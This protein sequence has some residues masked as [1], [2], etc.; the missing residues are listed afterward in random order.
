MHF[1]KYAEV[2]LDLSLNKTLTYG[3][4]EEL[5]IEL[6]QSV[7]VPLRS[8]IEN[9]IVVNIL[10]YSDLKKVE[11][12]RKVLPHPLLSLDLL[13]LAFWISQVYCVSLQEALLTVFPYKIRRTVSKQH[14][15]SPEIFIR[16]K[17][18]LQVLISWCQEH[19]RR[20]PAQARLLDIFI[21]GKRMYKLQELLDEAH[22]QDN[23]LRD[24]LSAQILEQLTLPSEEELLFLFPFLEQ[25][26]KNLSKDQIK[27][28]Q[29]ILKSFCQNSHQVHLLWGVTGSGKTE[30]YIHLIQA[31]LQQ[32]KKI[33]LLVPEISLSGQMVQ[34]IRSR[35][36]GQIALFHS[37]LPDSTRQKIHCQILEGKIDLVI[38]T[39]SA[40][41]VPLNP[42][43]LI[44]LDEEHDTSYKSDRRPCFHARDVAIKRAQLC[45]CPLILGSATPSMESFH[46]AKEKRYRLHQLPKSLSKQ[47]VDILF[48]P[49]PKKGIFSPDLIQ[50]IHNTVS[51]G[52]Q[53][54]LFLNRRGYYEVAL[55]K[56]CRQTIRCPHC[57][58]SLTVYLRKQVLLCHLCQYSISQKEVSC[59]TCQTGSLVRFLGYGTERVETALQR[60][61]PHLKTVRIDREQIT[62]TEKLDEALYLFRSG[63]AHILIGTQMITKGHHFP[64]VTLVGIL[65]PDQQL[66]NPDFRNGEHLVQLLT[67]VSGRVSREELPGKVVIQTD[68]KDLP[69]YRHALHGTYEEFAQ[70]E[71]FLRKTFFYPPFCHLV[72]LLFKHQ[73]LAILTRHTLAFREKLEQLLPQE[74]LLSPCSQV[75]RFRVSNQYRLHFVVKTQNW[76]RCSQTIRL[77]LGKVPLPRG[78][79]KVDFHP[80][81][82]S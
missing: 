81:S 29:S 68:Q 66:W 6:G 45:K 4:P 20:K 42:I 75:H 50:E 74:D 15:M 70:E 47:K 54:L 62:S 31:V 49:S 14:K 38:G 27:T 3:I 79:L 77:A 40:L 72:R 63:K 25:K 10:N 76:E 1:S 17:V 36:C 26:P 34:A 23:S 28:I 58:L 53:A 39:R 35:I 41:F 19:R 30:V 69:Y 52:E 51:R 55:C 21:K 57:D 11:P 44:I 22:A 71:L 5:C 60:I 9:G 7:E 73:D 64:F 61:F 46:A 33:I 8:R 12:I 2:A 65:D 82:L 59:V 13:H 16:K 32:G 48:V 43:G 80:L 67:Q 37:S 24:L 56:M 78:L 18:P